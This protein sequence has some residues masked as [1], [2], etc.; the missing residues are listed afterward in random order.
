[1]SDEAARGGVDPDVAAEFPGL[2]L[3]SLPVVPVKAH[4]R[5]GLRERLRDLSTRFHGA[6]AIVMR[7]EPVPSAYRAF[8]RQVGLDP[9]TDRTPIEAAAL[10]RL[11]AGRFRSSDRLSDALLIG[12]VETGVP[13]WAV[14]EDTL[15]GE[16]RIRPAG[17]E[18]LGT[19]EYANDLPPGRLVIADDEG[20]VAVLFGELA[21]E[22]EVVK[23]TLAVRLIAV[24]VGG[25]PDVHVEEALWLCAEALCGR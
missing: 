8:F 19:G 21:A 22:H 20:P 25:V 12:L 4:T 11:R 24:Q 16:L 17:R 6:R 7:S 5:D 23:S 9:D 3:W 15:V 13:L 10:E 18:R 14:D 1:M 2:A